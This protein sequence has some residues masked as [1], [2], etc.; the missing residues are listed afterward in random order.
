LKMP[1][2]QIAH[3]WDKTDTRLVFECGV[4]FGDGVDNLHAR[5]LAL[6]ICLQ[7]NF[8]FCGKTIHQFAPINCLIFKQN[9][10]EK[11][12]ML[13]KPL[14]TRLAEHQKRLCMI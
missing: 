13:W 6:P 14:F 3:S 8:T 12:I 11:K 1:C 2:M 4:K 10:L 7:K 9:I 5:I